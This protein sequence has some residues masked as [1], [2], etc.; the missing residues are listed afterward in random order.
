MK[1]EDVESKFSYL[2]RTQTDDLSESEFIAELTN[3]ITGDVT[4]TAPPRD[5][6]L[7]NKVLKL[8]TNSYLTE[9]GLKL[10]SVEMKKCMHLCYFMNAKSG[11]A[12]SKSWHKPFL[13]SINEKHYTYHDYKAK[14][15]IYEAAME[16]RAI[17]DKRVGLLDVMNFT[18]RA[19][20]DFIEFFPRMLYDFD[21]DR[22]SLA[23]GRHE[24]WN[25]LLN[26]FQQVHYPF[27]PSIEDKSDGV[28]EFGKTI[29]FQEAIN[30]ANKYIEECNAQCNFEIDLPC[31]LDIDSIKSEHTNLNIYHLIEI[32][33][34]EYNHKPKLE[35][36]E[37]LNMVDMLITIWQ[38]NK[39]AVMIDCTIE[40]YNEKNKLDSIIQYAALC[41]L[42]SVS[43]K[44]NKFESLIA[45][46]THKELHVWNE[47]KK[48]S[49]THIKGQSCEHYRI[50]LSRWN[51]GLVT[52]ISNLMSGTISSFLYKNKKYGTIRDYFF[53]RDF[54]W[55]IIKELYVMLNP[56]PL[57]TAKHFLATIGIELDK[58]KY[59][60]EIMMGIRNSYYESKNYNKE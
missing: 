54:R 20:S 56:Y 42:F 1:Y 12:I 17:I 60:C 30:H 29:L 33:E 52:L 7:K 27:N 48:M 40:E 6:N 41:I 49:R 19:I 32:A 21:D 25:V 57:T 14:N 43:K 15:G 31:H 9:G 36:A 51:E 50:E 2:S 4:Y 13:A 10:D 45:G 59:S 34:K 18:E 39:V 5:S 24:T 28:D 38:S 44:K 53:H 16:F 35:T 26:I 46:S 8:M 23:S 47:L 11:G 22:I 37:L 58:W 3:S 55:T